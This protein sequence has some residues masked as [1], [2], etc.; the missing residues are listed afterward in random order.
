[1]LEL[2]GPLKKAGLTGVKVLWTFFERR[3]QPLKAQAHPLFRYTSADDT[4][5]MS[6]E[7]LEPA[8][9][10]SRVW[11]VI[12]RAQAAD[13]VVE[14]DRHK[15][16]L[17]PEPATR[18]EGNNPF[19]VHYPPLPEDK[20]RW[21][22]NRAE[23]ERLLAL[24]QERK[25]AR[26]AWAAA[27]ERRAHEG[28]PSK[29]SEGTDNGDNDEDDDND[30]NLGARYADLLEL[31][32]HSVEGT[33]GE[34][35]SKHTRADL[36]QGSL[37]AAPSLGLTLAQSGEDTPAI[38]VAPWSLEGVP[39]G[40]AEPQRSK[41]EA[42]PPAALAVAPLQAALT[43]PLVPVVPPVAGATPLPM[44]PSASSLL[45]AAPIVA[46]VTRGSAAPI[47]VESATV[48]PEATAGCEEAPPAEAMTEAKA[49]VQTVAADG[50]VPLHSATPRMVDV[51]DLTEEVSEEEE[52]AAPLK[53]A[54]D[55]EEVEETDP[56]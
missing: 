46:A 20:D 14:L 27:N 22:A 30:D 29:E 52:A 49:G 37:G 9:V 33:S 32:K 31:G 1:M 35:S 19:S 43:S 53:A 23:N 25:R 16:G 10:R 56:E 17:A 44:H 26:A 50:V 12:R 15:A 21:A 11:A 34:P 42:P 48:Q 5:R 18:R 55:D 36:G 51:V 47:A 40:T 39:L 45:W 28:T 3:V 7:A 54:T 41:M 13:D 2:L 38:K 8:E 24:S 4:T 6:L